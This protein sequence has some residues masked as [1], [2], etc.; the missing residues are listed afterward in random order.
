MP[1]REHKQFQTYL[2]WESG[3]VGSK[4]D[5]FDA[6]LGKNENTLPG[7]KAGMQSYAERI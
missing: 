4:S 1:V 7:L 6:F 3:V 2:L 5:S